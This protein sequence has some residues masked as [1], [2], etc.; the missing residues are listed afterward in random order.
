MEQVRKF[1]LNLRPQDEL[2]LRRLQE[3]TGAGNLTE[4]LRQALCT[5]LE[6]VQAR[7]AAAGE[8][9]AFEVAP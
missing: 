4:A 2:R 9:P 6:V 1:T 5:A 7:R 8:R 3:L